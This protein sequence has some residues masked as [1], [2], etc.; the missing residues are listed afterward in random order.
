MVGSSIRVSVQPVVL[1]IGDEVQEELLSIPLQF[2]IAFHWKV[3]I[4]GVAATHKGVIGLNHLY[5]GK[6]EQVSTVSKG[7]KD[8]K[9]V[10]F[11]MVLRKR[12]AMRKRK[13]WRYEDNIVG[14]SRS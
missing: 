10:W 9:S 14:R 2:S 3:P 12:I 6:K 11:Q 13:R 4:L 7:E 5:K 1:E 8:N